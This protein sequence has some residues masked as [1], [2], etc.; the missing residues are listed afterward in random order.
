MGGDTMQINL[1]PELERF[2]LAKLE[3]GFYDSPGEVIGDALR[4]LEVRDRLK[5]ER[6]DSFLAEFDRRITALNSGERV[7]CDDLFAELEKLEH[8][9]SLASNR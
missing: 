7:D 9:A 6:L 5:S 4:A 8:S 3:S 1:P 2:V